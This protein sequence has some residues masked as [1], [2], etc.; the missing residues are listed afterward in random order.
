MNT[1][2]LFRISAIIEI[3]TGLAFL[4]APIVIVGLLLG[5]G[6]SPAGVAVARVLGVALL[7]VGVAGWE[8]RGQDARL[9]PR[10][11]L[12][13]YNVGAA[14]VLV[15]LGSYGGMSGI[16]LWPTVVLHA[17]IGAIMLR[18]IFTASQ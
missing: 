13:V 17:L 8:S 15:L 18:V 2:L 14:V 6:L 16:L 7:S 3:L 4:A 10:A 12:C 1:R 5:G 9:A 11:G